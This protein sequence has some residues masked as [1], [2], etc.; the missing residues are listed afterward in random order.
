MNHSTAGPSGD[1]LFAQRKNRFDQQTVPAHL[2][3]EKSVREVHAVV[4]PHFDEVTRRAL[5]K[6][7]PENAVFAELRLE[8]MVDV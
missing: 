8:E 3:E 7:L 4:R 2:F 6:D 5:S 1:G